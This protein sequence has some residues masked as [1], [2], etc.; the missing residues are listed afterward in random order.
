MFT[1]QK[2]L[3]YTV[4]VDNPN[5]MY[6]RMLQ[7]AIGGPEGELR[8]MSQ[9]LFQGFN[10]RGPDQYRDMLLSTAT[11]EIGH[12]EL[13]ATAVCMNLE[14]AKA[15]VV[16]Q[17]ATNPLIAARMGGVDPR[18]FL[19]MGLG[20]TTGDANGVPFTTAY[21]DS[22]G[23]LR[24]DMRAN[25]AAEAIGRTLATRLYEATDDPGMKDMWRFLIARDTMHQQ[26]WL[27]V[28]EELEDPANAPGD[29]ENEG[30]FAETA[31]TFFNHTDTPPPVDARW[32]S[33][34]S[35]DG[36]GTFK[37]A[38]PAPALGGMPQ[39]EDAPPDVHRG[40]EA[41]RAPANGGG[42]GAAA[43]AMGAIKALIGGG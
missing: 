33:G 15:D 20:A 22:G 40:P 26:Q 27:A 42:D 8:V 13:L 43:S 19:S 31:Y 6:A 29:F 28:L 38:D 30:E 1:H 41:T 7:Q 21:V 11:E 12:V 5:P 18:H 17:V 3:A 39:L 2:D 14:G 16:D 25:V 23:N 32:T 24:A 37:V 36:K 35:L 9:Y 10:A 34:P 4:R